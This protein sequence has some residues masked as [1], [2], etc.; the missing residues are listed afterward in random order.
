[1]NPRFLASA[2]LA[3]AL[4]LLP[5][6]VQA[7]P[8]YMQDLAITSAACI[9]P[10]DLKYLT[11]WTLRVKNVSKDTTWKDV[12]FHTTYWA[13]SGTKVDE[14]IIGHTEYVAIPPGKTVTVKF[15]EFVHEQSE[16]PSIEIDMAVIKN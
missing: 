16:R 12:H 6:A 4:A 11:A 10:S 2:V 13:Q 5:T 15:T 1:M 3:A 9:H 14:S 8:N 7:E